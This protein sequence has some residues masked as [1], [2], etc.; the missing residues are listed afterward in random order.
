MANR[1]V[2]RSVVM[3][4][5]FEWDFRDQQ[6]TLPELKSALE[7]NAHEF[8]PGMDDL[9]YMYELLDG[10]VDKQEKLNDVIEN[11][12]PHWPLDKIATVDRNIL[13][14]GLFELLFGDRSEVPPKVAID[15]AIELAKGFGGESSGSF[16]NGVI[17]A[18]YEEIGE[19][20]KDQTSD[21]KIKDIP[22]E[23]MPIEKLGGAV[24][25][26]ETDDGDIQLA[27][28]HDVFGHWTLPK[29]HIDNDD[30]QAGIKDKVAEETGLQKIDLEKNLGENE[31][32]A[33]DPDKG[34]IRKQVKY[35]LAETEYQDLA[36]PEDKGGL[37]DIGWFSLPEIVEL[38]FYDDIMPII[39]ESVEILADRLEDE[40]R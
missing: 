13:R 2:S 8:A 35:F 3:Q 16:V 20:G 30:M 32:V 19:P 17:G 27:L 29:G 26:A 1:H 6:Y 40:S 24:V 7:R 18:V 22:Y 34:K 31:Y 9:S 14:L 23:E 4:T 36:L 38:N 12:A 28:V 39:T 15:E 37:D 10:V 5:L 33:A 21:S 11:A 25:Y